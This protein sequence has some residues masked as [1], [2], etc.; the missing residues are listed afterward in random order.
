MNKTLSKAAMTRT[1]LRNKFIRSPSKVNK[2]KCTKYRNYC[3]KLLEKKRY[4]NNLDT[5]LVAENKT[6]LKIVKPMFSDKHFS[7]HK[8][9]LVEGDEL[10][11]SDKEVANIFN[12][13]FTNTVITLNIEGYKTKYCDNPM[14]D[15]ISNIVKKFE[16]HPSILKIK[17]KVKIETKFHFSTISEASTRE[18]I[19]TM[20]TNKPT[21]YNNIPTKIL[22]GLIISFHRL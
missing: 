18:M 14:P 4:Y 19:N 15:K 20:D 2:L 17:E 13:L 3:T 22:I 21:T 5:K 8:I 6:F 10:R 16:N 12:S 7:N 9:T 1:R 11:S